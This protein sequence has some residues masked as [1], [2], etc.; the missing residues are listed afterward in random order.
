MPYELVITPKADRELRGLYKRHGIW[1]RRTLGGERSKAY[2]RELKESFRSLCADVA[3]RP[4]WY[5]LLKDPTLELLGFRRFL[6]GQAFACVFR[7][8]ERKVIVEHVFDARSDYHH[9][10]A[11][12]EE[13]E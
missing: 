13:L 3:K 12:A 8:Q 7:I 2:L 6:V 5:P 9:L 1:A 4:L 10:L 11:D